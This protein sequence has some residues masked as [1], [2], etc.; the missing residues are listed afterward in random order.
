MLI[1]L[2]F[3]PWDSQPDQGL[4]PFTLVPRLGCPLDAHNQQSDCPA[5]VLLPALLPSY[6]DLI[7]PGLDPCYF[8]FFKGIG[9]KDT[10]ILLRA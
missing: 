3:R 1:P 2:S 6:Q 4:A 9:T 7:C 8:F 5:P 10:F